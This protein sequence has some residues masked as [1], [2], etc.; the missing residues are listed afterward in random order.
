M[1]EGR[2]I[3][4]PGPLVMKMFYRKMNQESRNEIEARRYDAVGLFQT[5]VS[6]V[7]YYADRVAKTSNVYPVE[8]IG[9]CPQHITT[10]AFFGETAAVETAM[11]MVI[12]EEKDR[13]NRLI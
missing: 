7:L 5:T 9:N 1:A 10:L 2:I 6:G 4:N 12:Q 3:Y 8:I 13:K 11:K